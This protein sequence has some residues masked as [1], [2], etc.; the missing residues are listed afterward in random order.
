[1]SEPIDL[2]S[3]RN[4]LNPAVAGFDTAADVYEK[5]RPSY[6][7]GAI[8]LLCD[9]LGLGPGCRVLD[10]AAGTGKLTRLLTDS[11]A[12][13]VAV[14][15]IEGMREVLAA[16]AEG[17]EVLDGTAEAIPLPDSSVDLVT[18]AQA[19][20]WFD[21]AAA[22]V[23]IDRV[24]RPGGG[25]ALIWNVRDETVDWVSDFTEL[26]VEVGGGRPYSAYNARSAREAMEGPMRALPESGLFGPVELARFANPIDATV[27]T[28]VERAASTSFIAAMPESDRTEGLSRVRA[29]LDG[30]PSL[31]GRDQFP[32]PHHTD[33]FW[34]RSL[35][36]PRPDTHRRLTS[37]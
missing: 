3:R 37:T 2:S 31:A 16:T 27:D 28:V 23:E 30:H 10:L 25:L 26:V 32:F 6:P 15:P 14:E 19:F 22:L 12:D 13:V 34:C 18:V 24:L 5:V 33:V 35:D 4:S 9:E 21:G 29:L 8:R 11:A 20:H 36:G 1:M 17:I 7:A